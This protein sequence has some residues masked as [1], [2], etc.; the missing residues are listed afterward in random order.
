MKRIILT[1]LCAAFSFGL[2]AQKSLIIHMKDGTKKEIPMAAVEGFNFSGKAI[3]NDGDYTDISNPALHSD[4]QLNITFKANFYT[5]DPVIN[6][7]EK[8]VYGEDWGILYG[9]TP[10]VT[11]EDGTIVQVSAKQLQYM[12]DLSNHSMDVVFGEVNTAFNGIVNESP[13]DLDFETSYYFRTFVRRPADNY[14]EEKYFYSKELHINTGKPY[15]RYYGVTIDTAPYAKTGYIIPSGSAWRALTEQNPLFA[16]GDSITLM[17]YWQQ[18]LV[19]EYIPLLK[20]LCSTVYECSDGKLYILDTIN[21]DF[22]K[23]VVNMLDDEMVMTGNAVDQELAE[24]TNQ[25]YYKTSTQTHVQCDAKWNVPNNEYWKYTNKTPT[26]NPLINYVLPKPSLGNYT[27]KIEVTFA[28]NTELSDAELENA[29]PNKV[30]IRYS[31]TDAEGK[32]TSTELAGQV[33]VDTR[34]ATTL[35]FDSVTA[36][37]FGW[38]ELKID[39]KVR[40]RGEDDKYDRV[41][42]IAQ[43]KV[44]PLGPIAEE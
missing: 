5:D 7:M 35:T 4:A 40:S 22:V 42:R 17:E 32:K 9:T 14:L 13:V 8:P 39:G 31:S 28:P 44:T 20:S 25:S 23:Y 38:A 41:L 12:K 27:Y 34:E 37:G 24:G 15:M 10:D 30:R 16:G 43:I 33:E 6:A 21:E 1:G 11:I 3:V 29:K 18:C 19:P 36:H 2:F 26:G